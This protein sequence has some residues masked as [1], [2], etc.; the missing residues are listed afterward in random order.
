ML[1]LFVLEFYGISYL[2]Q[3]LLSILVIISSTPLSYFYQYIVA[4]FASATFISYRYLLS[5]SYQLLLPTPISYYYQLLITGSQYCSLLFI[6]YLLPYQLF[7][8]ISLFS[9]QV[10]LSDNIITYYCHISYFYQVLLPVTRICS[11]RI[12]Q[13]CTPIRTHL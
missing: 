9:C 13:Q 4:P 10:L 11:T 2:Y 8:S 12:F 7:L 5:Y 1:F 6:S 3:A